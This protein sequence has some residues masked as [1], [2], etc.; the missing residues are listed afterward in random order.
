MPWVMP[1]MGLT[2]REITSWCS[3][4][5]QYVS[6]NILAERLEGQGNLLEGLLDRVEMDKHR[7]VIPRF[8]YCGFSSFVIVIFFT[9]AQ[10]LPKTTYFQSFT[11]K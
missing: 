7:Q 9:Q 4:I 1:L 6:K 5:R 8:S 11:A 3:D 10:K 2:M